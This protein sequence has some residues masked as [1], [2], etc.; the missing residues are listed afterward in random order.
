[1][2]LRLCQGF[3]L[4]LF[5]RCVILSMFSLLIL[6]ISVWIRGA[7]SLIVLSLMLLVIPFLFLNS[8]MTLFTYAVLLS[9]TEM[10]KLSAEADIPAGIPVITMSLCSLLAVML[11]MMKY[12]EE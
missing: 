4:C 9:G 3:L 2:D 12:V 7:G 1:M 6:G 5:V 10:L 11:G 8:R